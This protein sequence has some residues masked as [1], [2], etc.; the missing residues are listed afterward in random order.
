MSSQKTEEMTEKQLEGLDE[1]IKLVVEQ[2][3]EAAKT[4]AMEKS[5]IKS[6][7]SFFVLISAFVDFY[8]TMICGIP[9]Y[10]CYTKSDIPFDLITRMPCGDE[11]L[12]AMCEFERFQKE[13]PI[14]AFFEQK[15]LGFL[16]EE[17]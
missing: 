5:G 17:D 7:G 4:Y 8:E 13:T 3:F 1:Q 14:N 2:Y 16:N 15:G 12:E 11:E 10:A 6:F 9:I